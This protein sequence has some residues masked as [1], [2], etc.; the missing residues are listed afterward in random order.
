MNMRSRENNTEE[1]LESKLK[2]LMPF[3]HFSFYGYARNG[4]YLLI[5]AMGWDTDS[6]EI[7]TPAF[8][9]TVIPWTIEEAGAVP[10]PVDSEKNGLNI[11]PD[12]IKKNITERT[13]AVYVIHSY[14]TAA[15]IQDICSIA[16]KNSLIVIEDVAHCP[17]ALYRG[18]MLG[19]YG[20]FVLLSFNKKIINYEGGAIGTNSGE[21]HEKI[22]SLRNKY[23]ISEF[24]GR[25][26]TI[27]KYR[28]IGSLWETRHSFAAM[29]RL[30]FAD[31]LVIKLYYRG[32]RFKSV[33]E[34]KFFMHERAIRWT[35]RQLDLVHNKMKPGNQNR[36]YIRFRNAF[37]KDMDFPELN[38]KG[39]DS[40]PTYFTGLV[41][42]KS[43]F[44]NF[45]SFRTWI[46]MNEYGKYPRA[47][48]IYSHLRIFS[49]LIYNFKKWK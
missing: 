21:A 32:Q 37:M 2:T 7:I 19:T 26:W 15:R 46:N 42:R 49:G 29:I 24:E 1:V 17:F 25:D 16:K 5:K 9:C 28:F 36:R 38:Q 20:D 40:V 39:M 11:D 45:F 34:R 8:T 6:C 10:V 43:F 22:I 44:Y 23:T 14:G 35:L 31:Y 4:L 33:D 3:K 47:D 13:R 48:Y 12:E 30:K 41:R 27:N 18:K